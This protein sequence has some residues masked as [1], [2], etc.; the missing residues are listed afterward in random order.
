MRSRT[1]LSATFAAMTALAISTPAAQAADNRQPSDP[2][3]AVEVVPGTSAV[4]VRRPENAA[5]APGEWMHCYLAQQGGDPHV[6][7][8]TGGVG[9]KAALYC[10]KP[11]QS[12]TLTGQ[13][14]YYWGGWLPFSSGEKSMT[15]KKEDTVLRNYDTTSPKCPNADN[16]WWYG[17]FDGTITMKKAG[18]GTT[19]KHLSRYSTE[20]ELPCGPV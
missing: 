5:Q 4:L 2:S 6:R 15:T 1:I 13:M 19:T 7:K 9:V 3:T 18:G 12:L 17:Y 10:E 8:S 16:T 11:V 20:K 14:Y